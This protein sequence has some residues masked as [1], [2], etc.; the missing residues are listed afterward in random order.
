MIRGR[1]IESA[2][3]ASIYI[4]SRQIGVPKSLDDISANTGVT[5]RDIAR[6]YRLIVSS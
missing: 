3:A 5:P 6:S 1:T 2:L 4:A